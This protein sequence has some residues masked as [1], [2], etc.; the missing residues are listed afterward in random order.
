MDSMDERRTQT[1]GEEEGKSDTDNDLFYH[2]NG[3]SLSVARP[4][5]TFEIEPFNINMV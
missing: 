3:I 5:T 2:E 1:K 4:R